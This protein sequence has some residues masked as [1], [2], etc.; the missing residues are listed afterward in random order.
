MKP[1]RYEDP[2]TS[3]LFE[4][5]SDWNRSREIS[6]RMDS[7]DTF[8]QP[9]DRLK[10]LDLEDI[11]VALQFL[12]RHNV[13]TPNRLAAFMNQLTPT[14][15]SSANAKLLLQVCTT[16]SLTDFLVAVK[17]C[18]VPLQRFGL[19]LV[20]LLECH[21]PKVLNHLVQECKKRREA[22]AKSVPESVLPEYL[23][24]ERVRAEEQRTK[25]VE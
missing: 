22:V 13:M 10:M 16:Q 18:G 14:R 3:Q 9:S 8:F 24:I 1:V 23:E 11:Q 4:T 2:H 25:K 19:L 15:L 17:R 7:Q 5:V 20:R 12:V 6:F 21:A